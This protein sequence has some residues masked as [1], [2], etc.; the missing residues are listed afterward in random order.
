MLQNYSLYIFP[1][2]VKLKILRLIRVFRQTQ[3]RRKLSV[4]LHWMKISRRLGSIENDIINV[5]ALTSLNKLTQSEP[6]QVM[7]TASSHGSL[8]PGSKP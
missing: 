7:L 4:I 3:E 2:I 8:H 5:F 1:Q 6:N